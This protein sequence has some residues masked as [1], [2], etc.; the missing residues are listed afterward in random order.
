VRKTA[1]MSRGT[2]N[3]QLTTIYAQRDGQ[4]IALRTT[5]TTF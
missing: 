1:T 4:W 3:L 5:A 2:R